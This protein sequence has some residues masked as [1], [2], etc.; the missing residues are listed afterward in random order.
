MVQLVRFASDYLAGWYLWSSDLNREF[1]IRKD[2]YG[3][4]VQ[5]L[6]SIS[7]PLLEHSQ[8]PGHWLLRKVLWVGAHSSETASFTLGR[9]V[10]LK[11]T[12]VWPDLLRQRL[13]W[14]TVISENGVVWCVQ[15]LLCPLPFLQD[16][17]WNLQPSRNL[18][19]L[20]CVNECRIRE[21]GIIN[22]PR[23]V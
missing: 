7:Y 18:M 5:L 3:K 9:R 2:L 15:S 11:H 10:F 20:G 4:P 1:W 16:P 22:T 12:S 21:T 14:V 8:M 13:R 6:Y 17:L 19:L 23:D